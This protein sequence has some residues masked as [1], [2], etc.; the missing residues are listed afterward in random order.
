MH[1]KGSGRA[2]WFR[3]RNITRCCIVSTCTKSSKSISIRLQVIVRTQ[4]RSLYQHFSFTKYFEIPFLLS[5]HCLVMLVFISS[6]T[7]YSGCA[8]YTEDYKGVQLRQ[9][10][11]GI[12][13]FIF[14]YRMMIFFIEP[15]L[16][17]M[18]LQCFKS[19]GM[20]TIGR[21]TIDQATK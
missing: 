18:C 15:N 11:D 4:V 7:F 13:I 14:A 16:F 8:F 20:V 12:M 5:A 10:V 9:S 2:V 6:L 19:Y 21:T 3:F 17:R 1:G